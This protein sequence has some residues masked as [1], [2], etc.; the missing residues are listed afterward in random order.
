ML[1]TYHPSHSAMSNVSYIVW[2]LMGYSIALKFF[3]LRRLKLFHIVGSNYV[4]VLF[5]RN[6]AFEIGKEW[7]VRS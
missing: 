7:K 5:D 6:L 4:N 1:L 3:L 2:K